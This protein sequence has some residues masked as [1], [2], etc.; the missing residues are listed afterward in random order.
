MDMWHVWGRGEVHIWFWCVILKDR[1]LGRPRR[2]LEDNIKTD[3]QDI[4]PGCGVDLSGSR[5][6]QVMESYNHGND[7]SFSINCGEFLDYVTNY[8]LL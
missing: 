7:F 3:L 1:Q 2:K 8:Y 5:L 6:G 4:V